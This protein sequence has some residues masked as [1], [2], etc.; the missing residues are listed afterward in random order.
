MF[1][2][3]HMTG[4]PPHHPAT[5]VDIC[6]YISSNIRAAAA[7]NSNQI[8]SSLSGVVGFDLWLTFTL[9]QTL[10]KLNFSTGRQSGTR[11]R[12]SYFHLFRQSFN[13]GKLFIDWGLFV[14]YVIH[15]IIH[16]I[17]NTKIDWGIRVEV[18]GAETVECASCE[19]SNSFDMCNCVI[20][21]ENREQAWTDFFVWPFCICRQIDFENCF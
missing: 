17:K 14:I 3:T 7:S 5:A 20:L 6:I 15:I 8:Q 21:K 2:V 11:K 9:A 16:K 1:H 18:Y 19:G 12:N 10:D 13:S 4:L